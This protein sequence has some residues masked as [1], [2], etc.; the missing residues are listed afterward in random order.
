M[1]VTL[2]RTD[3][4]DKVLIDEICRLITQYEELRYTRVQ[5]EP[6]AGSNLPVRWRLCD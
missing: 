5:M 6:P 1:L 3:G 4:K 2:N